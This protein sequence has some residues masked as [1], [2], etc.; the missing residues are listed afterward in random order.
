MIVGHD[1]PHRPRHQ[2][3]KLIA[4]L[5]SEHFG[6]P[7][8][9]PA[10]GIS[11]Q[12]LLQQPHAAALPGG[13]VAW[14]WAGVASS[15]DDLERSNPFVRALPTPTLMGSHQGSCCPVTPI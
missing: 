1:L 6:I 13:D 9:R 7:M 5:P 14:P 15:M 12:R 10:H 2:P 8:N 11:F 4:F 3:L